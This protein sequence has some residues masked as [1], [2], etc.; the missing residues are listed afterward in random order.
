MTEEAT[1]ARCDARIHL[2]SVVVYA[3]DTRLA[4]V[5]GGT[6][7]R[8]VSSSFQVEIPCKETGAVM[9]YDRSSELG[10]RKTI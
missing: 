8:R 9:D 6:I 3:D 2:E 5:Q 7:W 1:L 10:M 4:A